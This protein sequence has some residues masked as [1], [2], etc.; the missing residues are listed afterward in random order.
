V[1]Q[2]ESRI[3]PSSFIIHPSFKAR[4]VRVQALEEKQERIVP[5]P[6]EFVG[7][8]ADLLQLAVRVRD[9]NPCALFLCC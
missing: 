3:H 2:L 1:A 5:E 9:E 7:D 6:F 4:V 8:S